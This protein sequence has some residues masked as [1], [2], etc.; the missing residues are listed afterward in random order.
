[1]VRPPCDFYEQRGAGAVDGFTERIRQLTD[2]KSSRVPIWLVLQ[3]HGATK[4]YD[5]HD[6]DVTALREPTVEELRLQH[7]L[8]LGEGVTGIFWFIYSTQ[9]FWTGLAANPPLL[10]EVS[11]LARRAAPWRSLTPGLRKVADRVTVSAEAGLSLPFRPYSSTLLS[12][13]GKTYF[14][15]ANRSCAPQRLVVTPADRRR[16]PGTL[17]DVETDERFAFGQA[18]RFRGG[19][20]RLFELVMDAQDAGRDS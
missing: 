10:A 11:D 15:V 19:D 16:L 14:V 18:L 2:L 13:D 4:R 7:W 9:Q 5:P 1:V 3:A 8:A 20:G 17:R 6:P 12:S